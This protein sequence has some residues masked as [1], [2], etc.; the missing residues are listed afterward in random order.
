MLSSISEQTLKQYEKPLRSWWIYCKRENCP[1]YEMKIP[2]L[3]E[4]FTEQ[5]QVIKSYSTL[6]V[7]RAA[8]SLLAFNK[9]SDDPQITRFFKGISNMKPIRNKYEET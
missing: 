2:D 7:Y 6:N 5:S 4:F 3:L 9:F 1:F 8:L